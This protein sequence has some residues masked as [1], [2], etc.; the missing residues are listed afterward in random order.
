MNRLPIYQI[1]AFAERRFA[2][3][4]AAV[5]FPASMLETAVMQAIATE[6]NLAETA[7]VVPGEDAFKIRW[8][9]PEVEVDLCGH[10]TLAAA[11]ALFEHLDHPGELICFSSKS[12]PLK[13]RR[14]DDML[15]LDFPTDDPRPVDPP[16]ELIEG[17]AA[18]PL[19]TYRG[20]DDY[21]AIFDREETVAGLTPHMATVARLPARG[22][23]VSAP[24]ETVDFVS[25]F[26][27]P[28]VGVP[29]DA[30]TGSAHTTLVPYWSRRLDKTQLVARQISR[31]QG[32]LICRD[33]GER[34]EIGGRA[35]TYL[36]GE[37]FL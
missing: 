8:F 22:L 36:V 9:T 21:L 27:G 15:F 6:N 17:L 19:E 30:V 13:V 16:R 28:Q 2:G 14:R 20:R 33:L 29:E 11:Q 26:F 34:V 3:N 5:V 25:R 32:E 35:V 10:A 23:I 37:I 1:D 18:R 24:G 7:F 12:G 31:R 4:P